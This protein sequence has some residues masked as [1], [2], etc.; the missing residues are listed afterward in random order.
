[1]PLMSEER[2]MAA[3][4]IPE[5]M[6]TAQRAGPAVQ[7]SMRRPNNRE[8]FVTLPPCPLTSLHDYQVY[9]LW[10]LPV[11]PSHCISFDISCSHSDN[12]RGCSCSRRSWST[13]KP[14]TSTART[15]RIARAVG[16]RNWI[17][18]IGS[19]PHTD[20][21]MCTR[22][23]AG[24]CCYAVLGTPGGREGCEVGELVRNRAVTPPL[25]GGISKPRKLLMLD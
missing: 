8:V 5:L 10:Q 19:S 24:R 18:V 20:L 21:L 13:S 17:V 9:S 15:P 23:I 2:E 14:A 6:H 4:Q 25:R 12:L 7:G 22:L 1:M 11:C 16:W 3:L